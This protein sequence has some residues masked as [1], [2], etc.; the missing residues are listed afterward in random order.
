MI[1]KKQAN[2]EFCLVQGGLWVRDFT[3]PFSKQLDINNLIPPHDMM[4]LIDNELKNS[5]RLWQKVETESFSHANIVIVG[6]GYH[7]NEKHRLLET[8]KEDV[9]V[10]GINQTLSRWQINRKMHYYLVNNPYQECLTFLP[11]QQRV[12]P[13]CIASC[14]TN[15]E[16]IKKYNGLVYLYSPSPSENYSPSKDADFLID[17]YRNPVCA[18]I[19]LAHKF[20][21]KK[22]LVLCPDEAYDERR[23]GMERLKNNL[24]MYPQQKI[25]NALMGGSLYW[26]AKAG[27]KVGYHGNGPENEGIAYIREGEVSSFFR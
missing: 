21:V 4:L 13:R 24:W 20:E 17:D 19:H 8:I 1:I 11:Q 9:A 15:P 25:A 23:E 12:W 7:F 3:K 5:E 26:L 22:L 16:F 2:N 14:R 10:I 27:V 6:D 18:A